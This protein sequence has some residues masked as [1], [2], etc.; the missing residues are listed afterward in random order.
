[1]SKIKYTKNELK[2]QKDALKRF[3]RYLPTLELK[4]KQL[5]T[6]INRVRNNYQVVSDK[7]S[8]MKNEIMSWVEVF[9]EEVGFTDIVKLDNIETDA[10]SIAGVDIPVFKKANFTIK[11]YDIFRLPLWIDRAVEVFKEFLSL[12]KERE[13]IEQ[14][15]NLLREELRTTTQRVNLFEKVK[16]PESRD[17]IRVINIFLGDEQTAGVVRGKI[18]KTKLV[19]KAAS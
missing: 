13:I 15:I 14:Q 18:A 17:N 2:K 4:R 16:I 3:S 9:G 12:K 11:K 7:E 8:D 10:A 5:Q 1:M 19:N 6:E